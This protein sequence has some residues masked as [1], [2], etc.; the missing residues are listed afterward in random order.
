MLSPPALACFLLKTEIFSVFFN[1]LH[2]AF[3]K[4]S[5]VFFSH[6]QSYLK[7]LILLILKAEEKGSLP[8]RQIAPF[9]LIMRFN[10]SHIGSNGI[11]LSHLQ[12]VVPYG[13]SVSTKSTE[14]SGMFFINSRQSPCHNSNFFIRHRLFSDQQISSFAYGSVSIQ[15]HSVCHSSILWLRRAW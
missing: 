1:G 15:S 12:A 2:F 4:P 13:G 10:C 11:T 9:C 7:C 8:K 6:I 5:T 3:I 14:P